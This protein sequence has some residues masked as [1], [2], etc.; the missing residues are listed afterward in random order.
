MEIIKFDELEK[1]IISHHAY[2]RTENVK[3]IVN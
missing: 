2:L 3:V 1:A